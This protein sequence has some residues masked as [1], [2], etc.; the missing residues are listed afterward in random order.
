MSYNYNIKD[1]Y[2]MSDQA[3]LR[4]LGLYI[5]QTRLN[6]NYTQQ[7]LSEKAGVH[8]VT[9]SEF[10]QGL[11]GSLTTFIQ[12]IRS[13]DELQTLDVFS[14]KNEISPLQMAKL[15]AKK[16]ERASGNRSKKK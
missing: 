4:E 2:S 3:I 12:L 8:R 1:W 13:L 11:R 9:L 7:Q 6:K 10:E 16:R 15:Q 5:K 14:V